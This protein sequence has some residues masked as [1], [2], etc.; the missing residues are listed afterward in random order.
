MAGRRRY[1]TSKWRE[2]EGLVAISRK[3][4]L[5]RCPHT[6]NTAKHELLLLRSFYPID[7]GQ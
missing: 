4:E 6:K 7:V 1:M 5:S 3:I 2:V